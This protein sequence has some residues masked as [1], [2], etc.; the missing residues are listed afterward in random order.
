MV[1]TQELVH[2]PQPMH[3][4]LAMPPDFEWFADP[5]YVSSRLA[6]PLIEP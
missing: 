5:F 2:D 4:E 6:K 1:I 3:P